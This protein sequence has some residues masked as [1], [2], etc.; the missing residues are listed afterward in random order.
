[1]NIKAFGCTVVDW[2]PM[3]PIRILWLAGCYEHCSGPSG[4]IK[5]EVSIDYLNYQKFLKNE[6]AQQS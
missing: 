2:K 3:P 6:Y 5:R 1:M 4:S